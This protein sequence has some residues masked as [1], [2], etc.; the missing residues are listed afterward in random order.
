LLGLLFDPEAGS[1]MHLRNSN[2][3]SLKMFE[4]INVLGDELINRKDRIN[5]VARRKP[6]EVLGRKIGPTN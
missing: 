2:Q 5:I 4:H 1:S 6:R 3:A